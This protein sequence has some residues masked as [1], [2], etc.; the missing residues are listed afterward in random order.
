MAKMVRGEGLSYYVETTEYRF[1]KDADE[2]CEVH[3]F[4]DISV[5]VIPP[6]QARGRV[7][8]QAID[9]AVHLGYISRSKGYALRAW[10][11]FDACLKIAA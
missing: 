7:L 6:V 10:I 4:G 11:T 9:A 8:S 1:G 2:Y 3:R 5:E